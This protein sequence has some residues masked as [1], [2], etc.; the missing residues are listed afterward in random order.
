[1]RAEVC[2][3]MEVIASPQIATGFIVGVHNA[4]GAVWRGRG[5][6]QERELAAKYRTRAQEL[7]IEFPYVSNVLQDL[8]KSYERDA[9]WHD[10]ESELRDRLGH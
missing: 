9:Q 1:M 5:G 10:T 4:R 2:D 7:A 3:A 6:D 8:A